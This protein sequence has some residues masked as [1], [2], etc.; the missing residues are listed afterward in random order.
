MLQ[1]PWYKNYRGV[2][3][4][5]GDSKY[6]CYGEVS[7]LDDEKVEITELP[8]GVWTQ[9][10]KESVLESMLGNNT[11]KSPALIRYITFEK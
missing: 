6:I 11:E 1:L 3:E 7:V 10:Y 9:T 2:I 4:P 8:I 5:L